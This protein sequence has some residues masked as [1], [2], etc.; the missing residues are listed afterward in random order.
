MIRKRA[1]EGARDAAENYFKIQVQIL[2]R[3]GIGKREQL[4]L[5]QEK[6]L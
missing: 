5:E 1:A 3:R 2:G 4:Q 6:D